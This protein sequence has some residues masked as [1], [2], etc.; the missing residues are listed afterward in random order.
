MWKLISN[1]WL[2]GNQGKRF[3]HFF[4]KSFFEKALLKVDWLGT[5]IMILTQ[6]YVF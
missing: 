6:S 2:A 1:R 3:S 4:Q 5:L